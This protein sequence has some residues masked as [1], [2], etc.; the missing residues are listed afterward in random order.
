[1][2]TQNYQMNNRQLKKI[3]YLHLATFFSLSLH[4]TVKCRCMFRQLEI[5]RECPVR[6]SRKQPSKGCVRIVVKS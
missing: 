5:S 1:M 4:W 2:S 6:A 3:K